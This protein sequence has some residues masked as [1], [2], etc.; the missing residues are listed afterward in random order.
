MYIVHSIKNLFSPKYILLLILFSGISLLLFTQY[1]F[2]QLPNPSDP[3]HSGG[4]SFGSKVIKAIACI[5]NPALSALCAKVFNSGGSSAL[6][7]FG[8]KV[9]QAING[10]LYFILTFL[11]WGA[12][13]ALWLAEQAILESVNRLMDI[14]MVKT[15][16]TVLRDFANLFFI[17]ILLVIAIATIL[18]MESYGMKRLLPTLILVAIF[19]NFSLLLTQLIIQ[20]TNYAALWFMSLIQDKNDSFATSVAQAFRLSAISNTKR[21]SQKEAQTGLEKSVEIFKKVVREPA[22]GIQGQ[23][24]LFIVYMASI[25]LFLIIIFV[26]IAVAVLTTIRT[27]VLLI[28][29]ILSP[30]AFLFHVLPA[31]AGHA[32]EWWNK[33]ISQALFLPVMLFFIWMGTILTQDLPKHMGFD[34]NDNN[35]L[36]DP[37]FLYA[38]IIVLFFFAAGLIAAQ[39]LGAIGAG[40]AIQWG[41][42]IGLGGLVAAGGIAG[43]YGYRTVAHK[44]A[45]SETMK[46]LSAKEGIV[47]SMFGGLRQT[48]EKYGGPVKEVEERQKRYLAERFQKLQGEKKADMFNNLS[49]KNQM[50]LL[51]SMS[52]REIG[53]MVAETPLGESQN[54]LRD[55]IKKLDAIDREKFKQSEEAEM[56]IIGKDIE[57]LTAALNK[58]P[59]HIEEGARRIAQQSWMKD[60][61]KEREPYLFSQK[62]SALPDVLRKDALQAISPEDLQKQMQ[63]ADNMMRQGIAKQIAGIDKSRADDVLKV[64]PRFAAEFGKSV[65][66]AIPSIDVNKIPKEELT[67]VMDTFFKKANPK[68]VKDLMNK[69]DENSKA[70]LKQMKDAVAT[71]VPVGADVVKEMAKVF[72][73]T[74]GN[75]PM[76]IVIETSKKFR[77]E[78]GLG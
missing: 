59:K 56:L 69:N 49:P 72:E 47:G 54:K 31:T 34:P 76:S 55:N 53:K 52:A 27:I 10:M 50:A 63:N 5:S 9:V 57:K 3:D 73:T 67:R 8:S 18:R 65:E 40:T 70:Y 75:R 15:G 33:L 38:F 61:G 16:W 78:V 71:Y 42:R 24:A 45:E 44:A 60:I 62:L 58:V 74:L 2:A 21:I 77:R 48:F 29:M 64:A 20:P 19:I 41:K 14:N 37:A 23:L 51:S 46:K 68:Q 35:P 30:M 22:N 17:F 32:R 13:L 26:A 66:A 43:Y 6:S 25:I 7:Y 11:Q 28:L 39:R 4:S 1:S 12:A 36:F